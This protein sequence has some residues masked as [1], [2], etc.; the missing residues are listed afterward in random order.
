MRLQIHHLPSDLSLHWCQRHLFGAHEERLLRAAP[1]RGRAN[2]AAAGRGIA[3]KAAFL[4][5]QGHAQDAQ[6]VASSQAVE[7]GGFHLFLIRGFEGSRDEGEKK[8]L[9]QQCH[10]MSVLQDV[11]WIWESKC[12]ESGCL[13]SAG[14]IHRSLVP[15]PKNEPVSC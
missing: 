5:V 12:M 14:L 13:S 4:A 9:E 11:N 7:A 3:A 15:T 8:H 6:L 2:A 10:I 1:A